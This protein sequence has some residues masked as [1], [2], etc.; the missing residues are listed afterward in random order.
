MIDFVGIRGQ[1]LQ[2]ALLY[3]G[4]YEEGKRYPLIVRV[5]PG[6]FKMANSVNG[7]GLDGGTGIQNMQM[8][9]SRG[10]AVLMPEVPQ[11]LGTPMRDLVEGVNAAVN[12]VIEM[13][14]ADPE[15]L[16]VT[17]QSYGGY[18]SSYTGRTMTAC[19]FT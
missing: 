11:E 10:Y 17:G 16:G 14:V 7:F 9:A 12:K 6:P 15:R 2:A 4:D 8:Y 1:K 5:Y 13:G 18:S 3:P 19:P